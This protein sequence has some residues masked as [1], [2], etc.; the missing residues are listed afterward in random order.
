MMRDRAERFCSAQWQIT[1]DRRGKERMV[2]LRMPPGA[3][4]AA[5]ADLFAPEPAVDRAAGRPLHVLVFLH[6]AP[7]APGAATLRR[8]EAGA[9]LAMLRSVAREPGIGR[10]SLIAF[11]LA[12]GQTLFRQKRAETIDF[13]ALGDAVEK[14][15]LGTVTVDR[16]AQGATGADFLSALLAD[17]IAEGAPDA[18]IFIGP[19]MITESFG[20]DR[21]LRTLGNLG[22]P[23]FYLNYDSHPNI[24]PWRDVIG[25]AVRAWRGFEHT[26]TRPRDLT[27]AWASVMAH[28]TK[29]NS[30]T[31][32]RKSPAASNGIF[33]K[34]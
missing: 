13:P 34:K 17:E 15:D 6:Y 32:L 20:L 4:G 27:A 7:R 26:I 30:P 23:T 14:L 3:V 21:S 5:D 25:T 1:V 18:L 11:N 22:V 2:Q 10:C 31:G 8:D 16:L 28:L 19:K 12:G 33:P 29:G 24:N 9:L